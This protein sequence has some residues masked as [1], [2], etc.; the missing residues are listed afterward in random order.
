MDATHAPARPPDDGRFL[1]RSGYLH[2]TV[3]LQ[4][5]GVRITG[6]WFDTTVDRFAITELREVWTM[7]G[8]PDP[9]VVTAAKATGL[10]LLMGG[11]AAPFLDVVG[12][13]GVGFLLLVTGG[14]G[15][16]AL[17]VRPRGQELWARYDGTAVQIFG[18]SDPVWFN[19]VC[20]ALN[21][22]RQRNGEDV[23]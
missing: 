14:T 21:R 1:D 7:N 22:A 4:R 3:F 2:Q 16:V 11:L 23:T 17:R 8:P 5:R 13:L 12:W 20:R 10:V 15:L 9:V 18:S 19:Q 6:C